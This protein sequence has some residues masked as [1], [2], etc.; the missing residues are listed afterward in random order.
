MPFCVLYSDLSKDK[1]MGTNPDDVS[2]PV[3]MGAQRKGKLESNAKGGSLIIVGGSDASMDMVL[4]KRDENGLP[5]TPKLNN[6]VKSLGPRPL[7]LSLFFFNVPPSK[8]RREG[9][10]KVYFSQ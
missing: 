7:N 6:K 1:Y 10:E 5:E 4:K 9:L 8:G 3:Y 2:E